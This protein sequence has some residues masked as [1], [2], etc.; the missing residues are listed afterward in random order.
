[1]TGAKANSSANNKSKFKAGVEVDATAV[2]AVPVS[3]GPEFEN[4]RGN[5]EEVAWDGSS[6]FVLAYRVQK[7]TVS[8]KSGEAAHKDY[9][10]GAML[11]KETEKYVITADK[12]FIVSGLEESEITDGGFTVEGDEEGS[13]C[14]R[15]PSSSADSGN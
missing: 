8:K 3:V 10:D 7:V 4:T 6:D 5:K 9:K 12:T 13:V 15:P 2:S 14:A 11:G 1:M